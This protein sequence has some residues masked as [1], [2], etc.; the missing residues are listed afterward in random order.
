M[1]SKHFK[2]RLVDEQRAA[3]ALRETVLSARL[4]WWS[5][6]APNSLW[7]GHQRTMPGGTV[8]GPMIT[9]LPV[10]VLRL[11]ALDCL[12]VG[13]NRVNKRIADGVTEPHPVYLFEYRA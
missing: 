10:I 2:N 9:N 7:R 4:E 11:D 6:R 1:L 3:P 12:I 8:A 13:N 5:T